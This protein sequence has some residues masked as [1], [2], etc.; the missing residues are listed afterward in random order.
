METQIKHLWGRLLCKL[1]IHNYVDPR[2]CSYG[3]TYHPLGYDVTNY[4]YQS[5]CSRC[6]H[7]VFDPIPEET[8]Y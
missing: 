8:G 5:E 6:G 2:I 1:G 4:A 7:I 3:T